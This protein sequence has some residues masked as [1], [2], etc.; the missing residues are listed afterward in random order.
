M[1]SAI[2][3]IESNS[4]DAFVVLLCNLIR[5]TH[6][7][8]VSF[9]RRQKTVSENSALPHNNCSRPMWKFTLQNTNTI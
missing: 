7:T 1:A 2:L 4:N 6:M 3:A 5:Y 8:D 9:Q